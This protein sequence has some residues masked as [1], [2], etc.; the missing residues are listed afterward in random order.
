[1]ALLHQAAFRPDNLVVRMINAVMDPFVTL[2][3]VRNDP[4]FFAK[5]DEQKTW[6]AYI[7]KPLGYTLRNIKKIP[8]HIKKNMDDLD[9]EL[10]NQPDPE[11]IRCITWAETLKL[12]VL[13][14]QLD[15]ATQI[16]VT[17][18]CLKSLTWMG[19]NKLQEFYE[20]LAK[21]VTQI[22]QDQFIIHIRTEGEPWLLKCLEKSEIFK[23]GIRKYE[24]Q[25]LGYDREEGYRLL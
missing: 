11:A 20:T 23:D 17:W 5:D 3:Q 13:S 12:Y 15:A 8:F 24:Q 2:T 21:L 25:G 19:D 1:M 7:D 22:G 10:Q 14:A 4:T 9:Y 16:E 6:L 18:D